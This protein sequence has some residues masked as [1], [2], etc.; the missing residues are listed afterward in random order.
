MN[1][2]A[3]I[4]TNLHVNGYRKLEDL[5]YFGYKEIVEYCNNKNNQTIVHDYANYGD[6]TMERLQ[7]LVWRASRMKR[8]SIAVLIE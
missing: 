3:N 6:R 4:V 7:G 8:I 1:V 5:A 2:T